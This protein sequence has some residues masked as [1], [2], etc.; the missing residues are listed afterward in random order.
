M[1]DA[2]AKAGTAAV[3]IAEQ[4]Q[5]C[6]MVR[7]SIT[8]LKLALAVWTLSEPLVCRFFKH[9]GSVHCFSCLAG[10]VAGGKPGTKQG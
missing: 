7:Q 4:K 9:L 1:P 10:L 2:Q 3:C 6:Y 5:L 8:P